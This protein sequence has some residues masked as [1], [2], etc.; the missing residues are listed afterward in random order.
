MN[1]V[2]NFVGAWRGSRSER[3]QLTDLR[4][5]NAELRR[6]LANLEGPAAAEHGARKL[7]MVIPGEGSYV[8]RGLGD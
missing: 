2:V 4:A 6:R 1:P 3:A 5:E 7:G 8:I